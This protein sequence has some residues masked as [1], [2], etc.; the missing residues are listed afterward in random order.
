MFAVLLRCG[1]WRW[2]LW[3][4][5][6]DTWRQR[7]SGEVAG[8]VAPSHE[9]EIPQTQDRKQRWNVG[10]PGMIK[11]TRLFRVKFRLFLCQKNVGRRYCWHPC[12]GLLSSKTRV[13]PLACV[14][15]CLRAIDSSNSHLGETLIYFSLGLLIDHCIEFDVLFWFLSDVRP[16]PFF[17][18]LCPF[19]VGLFMITGRIFVLWPRF[20]FYRCLW[21]CLQGG[22]GVCQSW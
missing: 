17:R 4:H 10:L 18:K 22:E 7:L 1:R 19:H 12:F 2:S 9:E 14:L 8:T 21:F 16:S 13:E 5:S 20:C 3:L 11:I 6:G 15:C